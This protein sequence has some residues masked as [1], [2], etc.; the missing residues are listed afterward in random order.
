[1]DIMEIK[2][3][4]LCCCSCMCFALIFTCVAL[5]LS[6]KSLEQGRFA[7]T[8]NWRSQQISDDVVTEPGMKMVG[9]G[10]MLLE[11][12]STFQTMYFVSE[13]SRRGIS[14][15]GSEI[16]RGP[17]RARTSDGLEM[18]LSVSFQW[19]LQSPSLP[20]LYGI[21]GQQYYQDEFVR[22]ARSALVRS[23]ANFGAYSYFTNRTSITA[24]MLE[25]MSEVFSQPDINLEV[26][27]NGM[28][29]REVDLPDD[30][31]AEISLTQEQMQEIEIANAERD[32]QRIAMQRELLVSEQQVLELLENARAMAQSTLLDNA[33]K[34]EQILVL[35]REQAQANAEILRV[36]AESA[37]PGEDPYETLFQLME[38][39]AV[40]DHEQSKLMVNL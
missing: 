9:L 13:H 23:A 32:E 14:G 40:N 24:S 16:I 3:I 28:Q 21:L 10:N 18:L 35:A 39:R 5:P 7:L 31:D 20:G 36:F 15:G 38:V 19:R 25:S 26:E 17:I 27:I 6:F 1:M 33:A 22:F 12:P 37:A 8:F 11:Y 34:V 4:P 2:V 29:L 30:F